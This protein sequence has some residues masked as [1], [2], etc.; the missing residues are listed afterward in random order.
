MCL[1]QLN[2]LG[3]H[4]QAGVDGL[5]YASSKEIGVVIMEPLLGGLLGE[6]VPQD[7]IK[8]WDNSGIKRSPAEWAFRWLANFPEVTVILSG[9]STMDQLK[10]NIKI[11]DNAF[12][13]SMSEKEKRTVEE[14]KKLY[15]E[16]IKVKCTG[17]SYCMPCPSGVYIPDVFWCYNRALAG[18]PEIWKKEY[19]S[20]FC[21]N[22]MD[23]SQCI[24]CG[25]CE[26][27]CPQYIDIINKLKEAHKYL[28]SE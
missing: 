22:E 23:A 14:V 12:P 18:D 27:T 15:E 17:C 4:Y 7:I 8:K 3:E 28:I 1:I 9:V 11:F 16:K 13:N 24:E 2:F 26:E 5:K 20:I 6:N 21:E 25:Q 10:E 19:K